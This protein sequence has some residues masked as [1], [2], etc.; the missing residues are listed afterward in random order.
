MWNQEHLLNCTNMYVEDQ[1]AEHFKELIEFVKE[2]EMTQKQYSVP[3]GSLI[4]G[5]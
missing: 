4:P 2:A 5:N 3:D 1:L